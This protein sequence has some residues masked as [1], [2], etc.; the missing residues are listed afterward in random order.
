M[1]EAE[2]QTAVSIIKAGWAGRIPVD[3]IERRIRRVLPAITDDD[4]AAAFEQ[5]SYEVLAEADEL[6][7][8]IK[9]RRA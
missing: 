9:D 6:R 2:M 4:L 1:T 5:A 8:F 7:Q 3:A